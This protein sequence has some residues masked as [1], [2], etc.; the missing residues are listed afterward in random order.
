MARPPEKLARSSSSSPPAHPEHS[1]G[2]IFGIGSHWVTEAPY[3]RAMCIETGR[4]FKLEG[5][6]DGT[7][8]FRWSQGKPSTWMMPISKGI[9][10]LTGMKG[11]FAGGGESVSISQG[12]NFWMLGGTSMQEGVGATAQCIPYNQLQISSGFDFGGI[13]RL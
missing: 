5:A 10:M 12:R 9:C 8:T 11:H 4:S 7:T 2:G 13:T 6:G 3:G 1:E